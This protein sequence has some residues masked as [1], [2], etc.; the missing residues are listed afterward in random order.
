MKHLD[1]YNKYKYRKKKDDFPE[2]RS[3]ILTEMERLGSLR[4]TDVQTRESVIADRHG[5]ALDS[6]VAAIAAFNAIR[7]K[8]AL[9]PEDKGQWKIEGYVYV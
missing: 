9:I 7:H 8:D 3:K 1:L 4:F 5:D 6:V 2:A